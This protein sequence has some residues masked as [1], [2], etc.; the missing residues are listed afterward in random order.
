MPKFSLMQM[1][2]IFLY[3]KIEYLFPSIG[4]PDPW[5]RKTVYRQQRPDANG[6]W[7]PQA[8]LGAK[9]ANCLRVFV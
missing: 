1:L 7:S 2:I 5:Q 4:S 9:S 6:S 3:L 8:L